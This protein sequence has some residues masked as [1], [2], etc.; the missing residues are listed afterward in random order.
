MVFLF[1]S[2]GMFTRHT[3]DIQIYGPER[4]E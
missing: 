2:L 1:S 4:H 3:I